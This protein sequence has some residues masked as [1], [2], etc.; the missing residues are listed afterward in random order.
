MNKF[1]NIA[2][3]FIAVL[4]LTGCQMNN[5]M[6]TEKSEVVNLN[7]D[8]TSTE[9]S[10]F[11]QQTLATDLDN[12]ESGTLLGNL[13]DGSFV[14]F[15][16]GPLYTYNPSEDVLA[17]YCYEAGSSHLPYNLTYSAKND[18]SVNQ[19]LIPEFNL[20][21][22]Y[23]FDTDYG[24]WRVFDYNPANP[25][26]DNGNSEAYQWYENEFRVYLDTDDILE[27]SDQLNRF[28]YTHCTPRYAAYDEMLY[29]KP[30]PVDS[31]NI[32]K[33]VYQE[34]FVDMDGDGKQ[35]KI[36]ATPYDWTSEGAGLNNMFISI[37]SVNE[38]DVQ[39][40]NGFIGIYVVDISKDDS[41]KEVIFEFEYEC[42]YTQN[43]IIRYD[44][45]KVK[46]EVFSC[47][48]DIPGNGSIL[49]GDGEFLQTTTANKEFSVDSSFAFKQI[50]RLFDTDINVTSTA[51]V[52]VKL[53]RDGEYVDGILETGTRINIYQVD[54]V[55]RAFF[56]T[57]TG[58]KGLLTVEDNFTLL[59]D[60]IQTFEC[61]EGFICGG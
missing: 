37:N 7:E 8:I 5:N 26:E 50:E 33:G 30:D 56:V 17:A 10:S 6:Q 44:G 46:Y 55:S 12:V 53:N 23:Y 2:L 24:V 49:V 43:Y 4:V 32:D 45:S 47:I 60:Q 9:E 11:A 34:I 27:Y 35:E 22:Y 3:V 28:C 58:E 36:S 19:F 51:P 13:N 18:G 29:Y 1:C 31:S 41:Y 25:A 15:S 21:V 39:Y 59:P 57:E 61:F 14:R 16:G 52:Q 42:G 20:I 48:Y 40:F 38:I 54:Y